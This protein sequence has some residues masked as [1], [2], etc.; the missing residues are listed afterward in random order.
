MNDVIG[1]DGFIPSPF[2]T[3]RRALIPELCIITLYYTF[4]NDLCT[5][6][7]VNYKDGY[8]QRNVRQFLHILASPGYDP[9]TIAINFTRL[10]RGFNA[11]FNRF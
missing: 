4:Q 3:S 10:E 1:I 11:I 2:V 5:R 7:M 8:R 9:G 6:T